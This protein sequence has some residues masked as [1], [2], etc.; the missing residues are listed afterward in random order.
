VEVEIEETPRAEDIQAVR[1]GLTAFN[2][3][4]TAPDDYRPLNVFVRDS[5]QK[6]R[7]GLLG[8]TFW[9]WLH[10][11]I[12]WVDEPVRRQGLGS[13]L[14]R[15]AETEA[16]R[17]GC[18]AAFVDTLSFQAPGFYTLH[19]YASWG[20]LDGLPPGHQRVFFQKRLAG[21]DGP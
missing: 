12:L 7:A 16:I 19:G 2:E 1:D 21:D 15:A 5:E 11:S 18:T 3:L 20:R 10:I 13:Q 17:R 6:V 8:E 14:L 9:E 4:H